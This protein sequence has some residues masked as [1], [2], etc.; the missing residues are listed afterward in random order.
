MPDPYALAASGDRDATSELVATMRPRL[1]RMAAHYARCTG[2]DADDLLQE[3]WSGLLE[4][5]PQMDT[6]IGSPH[7]YL[8]ARAR[9]RL[10]DLVR[11]QRRRRCLPLECADDIPAPQTGLDAALSDASVR[12]FMSALQQTQRTVLA[13]LL[14]GLTWREA[15]ERMGCSSANVAYHVR[16]IRAEY[17]RWSEA[18]APYAERETI[19]S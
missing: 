14:G 18:G 11:R 9:W 15:G 6:A 4:A 3:A 2:E 12:E 1:A 8:L 19:M 13:H 17:A 16:R 7:Q 5:L 10:L